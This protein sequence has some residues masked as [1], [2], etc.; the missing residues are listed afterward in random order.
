MIWYL[1]DNIALKW[2]V[3]CGGVYFGV[4]IS[5]NLVNFPL[6]YVIKFQHLNLSC[7]ISQKHLYT[8]F[9]TNAQVDVA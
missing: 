2:T 1:V 3:T 8:V 5:E 6:I 4:K 7:F 9:A